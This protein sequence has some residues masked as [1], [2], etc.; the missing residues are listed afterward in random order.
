[1]D[2]KSTSRFLDTDICRLSLMW[3]DICRLSLMWEVPTYVCMC[4][5]LV[6]QVFLTDFIRIQYSK[7]SENRI[8]L[9][10]IWTIH[11]NESV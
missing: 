5:T 10:E 3:Y 11:L 7:V 6:P 9:L 4:P 2:M 1:M 8:E